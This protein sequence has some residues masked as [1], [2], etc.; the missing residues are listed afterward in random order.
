MPR[1]LIPTLLLTLTTTAFAQQGEREPRAPRREGPPNIER[2]ADG[3]RRMRIDRRVERETRIERGARGA[4]RGAERR[5]PRGGRPGNRQRPQTSERAAV[6]PFV[7]ERMTMLR[8]RMQFLRERMAELRR[9]VE[10]RT[11]GARQGERRIQ[12]HRPLPPRAGQR[13]RTAIPVNRGTRAP[14][15]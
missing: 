10:R 6:P 2:P 14:T 4:E 13:G 1:W 9:H 12:Q 5:H 15:S 8:E 11:D 3:E 7:R